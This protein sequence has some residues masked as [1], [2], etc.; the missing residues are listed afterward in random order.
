VVDIQ[1]SP[2]PLNRSQVYSL[3]TSNGGSPSEAGLLTAIAFGA[4]GGPAESSGNQTVINDNPRTGDYS[5]GIWQIN[6]RG[7]N[8]VVS[9]TRTVG[10]TTYTVAGLQGDINAQAQ[11]ALSL[12]RGRGIGNISGLSNEWG[13][14]RWNPSA[15]L[16]YAQQLTNQ[17]GGGTTDTGGNG[18]TTVNP[19]T[20]LQTDTGVQGTTTANAGGVPPP[21]TGLNLSFGGSIQHIIFQFLLIIIAI[22]LLLGGIY[23]LGSGGKSIDIQGIAGKVME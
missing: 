9:P 19:T 20:G 18:Q 16:A 4:P 15:V 17:F 12:L 13:A 5:V 3:V 6:F 1:A 21:P 23:L 8:G 11:A 2:N 7:S 10:G 22:A 14:F